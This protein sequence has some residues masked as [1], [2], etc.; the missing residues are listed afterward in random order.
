ML[1][2][3]EATTLVERLSR[4]A[5]FPQDKESVKAIARTLAEAAPESN[6]AAR[7]VEKLRR[8]CQFCPTDSEIFKAADSLKPPKPEPVLHYHRPIDDNVRLVCSQGECDGSG[9]VFVQRVVT[10]RDGT[11]LTIDAVRRCKCNP[12][13]SEPAPA[14]KVEKKPSKGLRQVADAAMRAAG[15]IA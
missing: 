2:L 15:D 10:E 11:K 9:F 14:E 12:A 1:K 7:T 13:R 5:N 8:E 6:W 3:S 4:T